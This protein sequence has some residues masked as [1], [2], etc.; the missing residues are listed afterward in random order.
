MQ[1]P[2]LNEDKDAPKQKHWAPHLAHLELSKERLESIQRM[3]ESILL[4]IN[5]HIDKNT[6]FPRQRLNKKEE[7]IIS[8][9][10]VCVNCDSMLSANQPDYCFQCNT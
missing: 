8:K 7:D 2:F 6:F 5:D 3:T 9:Q 4:Q 1:L 10:Q